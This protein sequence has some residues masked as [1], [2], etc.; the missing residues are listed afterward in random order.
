MGIKA[1]CSLHHQR[2]RMTMNAGRRWKKK[3]LADWRQRREGFCHARRFSGMQSQLRAAAES[4]DLIE[5]ESAFFAAQ[6]QELSPDPIPVTV[7]TGFLGSGKTTLVNKILSE[8]HGKKIAVIINEVRKR[9]SGYIILI[10]LS[11]FM[12][13]KSFDSMRDDVCLIVPLHIPLLLSMTLVRRR[14]HRWGSCF[15]CNKHI[16]R[17]HAAKQWMPLLYSSR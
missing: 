11:V 2:G 8:D 6:E 17:Y 5:D 16:R 4:V 13:N 10:Y 12:R 15:K 3:S 7:V 1:A 9:T 14:R